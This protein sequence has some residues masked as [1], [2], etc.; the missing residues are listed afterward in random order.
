[1]FCIIF[2]R[3]RK[4]NPVVLIYVW[5]F[6][7][8][9]ICLWSYHKQNFDVDGGLNPLKIELEYKKIINIFKLTPLGFLFPVPVKN[10]TEQIFISSR[11]LNDVIK[12]LINSKI[13]GLLGIIGLSKINN[14]KEGIKGQSIWIKKYYRN[15]KK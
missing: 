10:N 7:A 6:Y 11:E 15:K 14:Q 12:S 1:M 9:L 4:K 2:Y 5:H 13:Y 8:S 3:C